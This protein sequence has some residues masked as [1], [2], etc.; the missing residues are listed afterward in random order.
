V[1]GYHFS[2]GVRFLWN[3]QEYTV[4]EDKGN[5]VVVENLS[6]QRIE[7][8][9]LD[10]LVSSW[11]DGTLR[12]RQDE[13]KKAVAIKHDLDLYTSEDKQVIEYRFKLIEPFINGKT[14]GY[15][16]VTFLEGVPEPKPSK[17]TFYRWLASYNKHGDKRY[18]SPQYDRRGPQ[19][20]R[21]DPTVLEHLVRLLDQK[22]YGGEEVPVV[23]IYRSLKHW[24]KNENDI[25]IEQDKLKMMSKDTVYR[26]VHEVEDKYRKDVARHGKVQAELNKNG[27][28]ARVLAVRPLERVEIDWTPLDIFVVDTGTFKRERFYLLLAVDKCST[29]PLGFHISFKEPNALDVKQCLLHAMLPKTQLRDL[30]PEVVNEW[31]AWGR[32][33]EIVVDNAKVNESKDLEDVIRMC[34]IDIQYCQ[35]K[36]GHQKG[37]VEKMLG[38]LNRI[39]H[40]IAGTTLSNP[41]ERSQYSS[42]EKACVTI[43][44]LYRII[45]KI[46][47]DILGHT[48]HHDFG[49]TRHAMWE[50]G[51]EAAKVHRT[52]P[53]A[54]QE[55]KLLFGTGLEYR[56][57][58][59]KGVEILGQTYQSDALM[60]LRLKMN[61]K[62]DTNRVRI[63]FDK[64]DMRAVYVHDSYTDQFIEV[65]AT[66]NSLEQKG[67]DDGYP[68]HYQ[69]LA[70]Y[71]VNVHQNIATFD[72]TRIAEHYED[73]DKIVQESKASLRD[74]RRSAAK[75]GPSPSNVSLT[76]LQ[77]SHIDLGGP[78]PDLATLDNIRDAA[79]E[80]SLP[81]SK[82]R[83]TLT[84][85]KRMETISLSPIVERES[86]KNNVDDTAWGAFYIQP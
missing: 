16:V 54:K 84:R 70:D 23:V 60:E 56:K 50:K 63:R 14:P 86:K 52:L 19:H 25:R 9:R 53:Y 69:Q 8:V 30:Y 61:R 31:S 73:L 26:I 76:D 22:F 47:V 7:T 48:I 83:V 36:A 77:K 21:P 1:S 42:E 5:D 13:S 51:L 38:D 18:L 17:A 46:L 72:D 2:H 10:A 68:V 78:I 11:D 59:N 40:Q 71:C 37:T 15:S 74:L 4:R 29:Y 67:I 20:R 28:S 79:E 3:D 32:P 80:E 12:F 85:Q 39:L 44:G 45:H 57:I 6:Y 81:K 62:K 35:V 49:M 64:D 58:T 33:E 55:L 66:A 24:V 27:A 41:Q 82:K 34:G 65:Y 75:S 43:V